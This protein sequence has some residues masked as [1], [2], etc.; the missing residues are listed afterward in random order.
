MVT[1]PVRCGIRLATLF[2]KKANERTFAPCRWHWTR[3]ESLQN[4]R[5]LTKNA[6]FWYYQQEIVSLVTL[7]GTVLT[8]LHR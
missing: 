5:K 8:L 4:E 7:T 1:N 6:K 2:G 3:R